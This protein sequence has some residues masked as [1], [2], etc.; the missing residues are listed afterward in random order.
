MK[1][2]F[3]IVTAVGSIFMSPSG[4]CSERPIVAVFDVEAKRVDLSHDLLDALAD[5][6]ATKLAETGK[7]QVVPRDQIRERISVQKKE[8]YKTCFDQACQI[9]MGRELAA[10]KTVAT[11]VSKFADVCTVGVT[12]YDLKK[13]ATE[14]AATEEGSCDERSLLKALNSVVRK[15]VGA[16]TKQDVP[17]ITG[18]RAEKGMSDGG[19][20][21]PW[22]DGSTRKWEGTWT[23]PGAPAFSFLLTLS[24]TGN[25]VTGEFFWRNQVNNG[26]GIESVQGIYD[27]SSSRISMRGTKISNPGVISKDE[28][29]L[30]LESDLSISGSTKTNN[31]DW[32]GRIT[33]RLIP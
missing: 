20:V 26:T 33:G 18:N 27:P 19:S 10:E 5:Y 30:K 14:A 29:Q 24:R 23:R 15:F 22:K 3:A 11:Q 16:E 2:I 4:I 13:A 12:L 31:N 8:S 6:L 1:R 21:E 7:Y 25:Q 9:E 17:E 28:Y 32:S